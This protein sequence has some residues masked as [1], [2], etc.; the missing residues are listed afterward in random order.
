MEEARYY[1]DKPSTPRKPTVPKSYETA[2]IAKPSGQDFIQRNRVKAIAAV[3]KNIHSDSNTNG[4]HGE[5]GR[6]PEYL[7]ERKQRWAEEK[8]DKRRRQPD[9]NCPPG[10][11]VMPEEERKDTLETLLRSK[12]EAQSQLRKFPIVVE[13]SSM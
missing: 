2:N 5:Y 7:E 10:M 4:K 13:T 12:E 3:P 8:E 6:V 9:P 11:C 1:A